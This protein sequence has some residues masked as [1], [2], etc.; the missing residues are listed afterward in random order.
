MKVLKLLALDLGERRIGLAVGYA[1]SELV[2]PAGHL[3]REKLSLD[4]ERVLETAS[5]KDVQGFVVGIPYSINGGVGPGAK[6]AQGFVR[7]LRRRTKLPVYLVDERFTSV[8][9]EGLL[10]EAGRQASREKGS[11]DEMAAALIL[12]RFLESHNQG[13]SQ[14]QGEREDR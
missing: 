1:A 5:S 11:V 6:M 7:A 3:D 9:A 8:E 10:R 2:F 4:I 14:S 12:R 13:G